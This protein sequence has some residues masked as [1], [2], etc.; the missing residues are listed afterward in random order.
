MMVNNNITILKFEEKKR[1]EKRNKTI[2]ILYGNNYNTS[3][4]DNGTDTRVGLLLWETAEI[5]SR[6]LYVTMETVARHG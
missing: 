1:K 6:A 5:Q 3:P 2:Q 4:P